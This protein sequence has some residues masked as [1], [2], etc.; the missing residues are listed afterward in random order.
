MAFTV[1]Q[2]NPLLNYHVPIIQVQNKAN[3]TPFTYANP[4]AAGQTFQ[5]GAPVMLS[6][7]GFTQIW[8]GSLTGT[9]L[10]IA[11]SNGQGLA[12]NGYGA[13]NPPWGGIQGIGATSS[14]PPVPPNQ[15]QGVNIALGQPVSDG[16][17]LFLSPD[18]DNVF[19]ATF[20][21]STYSG[22]ATQITPTQAD[23][24]AKYGL[25]KEPAPA[26]AN[27]AGGV[28]NG[29]QW[30]VDKGLTGVNAVIQIVGINSLDGN[31]SGGYIANA[32]VR[33]IILPIMAQPTF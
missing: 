6:A 21:N 2:G 7:G 10:G 1:G 19:E 30:Y 3:T 11:E 28:Y 18:I 9:I 32:R 23:I 16:R 33:F 29:Y 26:S 5:T 15:P 12:S 17:T 25:N 27:P 8:D 14:Y 13:P 4:E 24:G 31:G 20:D 22:T